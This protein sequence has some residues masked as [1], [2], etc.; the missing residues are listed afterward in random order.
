MKNVNFLIILLISLA[1]YAQSQKEYVLN[2]KKSSINWTGSYLFQFSEHTGTVNF[3]K[4]TLITKNGNVTGGSFI[5]DMTSISNEAYEKNNDYGPVGHLK[6]SD[7][8]D[9]EKYPEA[10]LTLT[11]VTYYSD[12]NE[13]RFEGDLTIKGIS[14]SIMIKAMVDDQT[15]TVKTKFKI[16][17]KD[18]GINYQSNYKDSAISDAIEFD[19]TLYF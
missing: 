3:K 9:V 19:V 17:R 15:K 18:W 2:A 5:I 1:S 7:F 4:G 12:I 14:K 16:D 6:N 11:K 8:F 13:H 10:S